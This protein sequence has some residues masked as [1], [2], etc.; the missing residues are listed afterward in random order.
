[1]NAV[2]R[3]LAGKNPLA[4]QSKNCFILVPLHDRFKWDGPY[5]TKDDAQRA[6]AQWLIQTGWLSVGVF[7][8]V[9]TVTK[10]IPDLQWN[11]PESESE[12]PNGD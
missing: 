8:I 4:V 12:K 2:T 6:A 9:G 7:Q 1:M 10:P 5:D 3:F 11:E